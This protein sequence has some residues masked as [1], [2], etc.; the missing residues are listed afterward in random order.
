MHVKFFLVDENGEE[1]DLFTRYRQKVYIGD[2]MK[3][4]KYSNDLLEGISSN[5][6]ICQKQFG[7]LLFTKEMNKKIK[8]LIKQNK[9]APWFSMNLKYAKPKDVKQNGNLYLGSF[10]IL[11]YILELYQITGCITLFKMN[12]N[13]VCDFVFDVPFNVNKIVFKDHK[14]KEIIIKS[15]PDIYTLK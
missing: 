11:S 6:R 14:W 9:Y 3:A 2:M 7:K 15:Y 10:P 5:I 13:D 1:S 8:E 12:L 4:N